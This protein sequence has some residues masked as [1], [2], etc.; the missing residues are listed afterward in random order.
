MARRL[1]GNNDALDLGK[2]SNLVEHG[3][4]PTRPGILLS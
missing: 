1:D 3:S 4:R 2:V